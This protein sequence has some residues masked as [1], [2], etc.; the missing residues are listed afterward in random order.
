MHN[1]MCAVSLILIA[2]GFVLGAPKALPAQANPN[3]A[4]QA[5]APGKGLTAV[6]QAAAGKKYLFIFFF[7][8]DDEQTRAAWSVFTSA[9]QRVADRALSVA[10]NTTDPAESGIVKQFGVDRA[11]M[12]LAL[13]LAPNGAITGS[14]VTQFTQQ[15]LLDAFA[16]PG[17]EMV[18]KAL[19]QRRLVLLCAQNGRTR[20]NVQAMDGVNQFK[21][22]PRFAQATDVI[23]IDPSHPANLKLLSQLQ[24]DPNTDEA[25]TVLIA[26]P[27]SILGKFRG[28]VLKDQLASLL[29]SAGSCCPAGA[30]GPSGCAVPQQ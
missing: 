27:G 29:T 24:V 16:G 8:R 9:T 4:L 28:P 20:S 26:P 19:Q 13:V 21:A 30:C 1:V 25:T 6:N 10:V 7:T 11:P 22:D 3:T 23:K 14:F 17:A 5:G 12:P 15:Q 18:M 2:A